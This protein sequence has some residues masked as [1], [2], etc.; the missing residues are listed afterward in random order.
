MKK[1][2]ALTIVL[3]LLLSGFE[4]LGYGSGLQI[5]P[6][7]IIRD[8]IISYFPAVKG[9]IEETEGGYVRLH[10]DSS[11]D[12]NTGTRLS[13]FRESGMIYHPVTKEPLG[14]AETPVGR[15]EVIRKEGRSYLCSIIKG[16]IRK[17]DIARI[18]SSKIKLAFFQKRGSDWQLSQSLYNA[19]K[20]SNRFEILETF[21]KTF[22]PERLS[23]IS[24]ELGAEVL[25]L[26]ST[27]IEDGKRFFNVELYWTDD[28]VRF[29]RIHEPAG[30]ESMK[31]LVP[32]GGFLSFSPVDTEPWGSYDLGT[33]ELIA[34]GDV[35]GDG[36]KEIVVSDGRNIKIY[37]FKD[38][39]REVWRIG[40]RSGERHLS[41]DILDLN[42]NGRGEIFVTSITGMESGLTRD[43]SSFSPAG[44][45][46]I[47]SFI[48]EYSHD[49]GYK[50]IREDMPY[51]FRVVNDR[52]LMQG[53]SRNNIFNGPV[54]EVLWE[55]GEYRPAKPIELPE[56]VNIYGFAYIQWRNNGDTYLLSFDPEGYL[57][58]YK[59]GEEIWRSGESFGRFYLTFERTTHSVSKPVEKWSIK[60]RLP[61]IKTE[62]GQEAIV[63]KKN[64]VLSN[65]PG[66]GYSD[67]S[68]YLLWWNGDGLE[69]SLVMRNLPGIATD[70]LLSDDE[71]FIIAKGSLFSFV[72]NAFAGKFSRGSKLYYYRFIEQ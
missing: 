58:L 6:A 45:G 8:T 49:E 72:K 65:V 48:I 35:D 61:I 55:G 40:G 44:T 16:D 12:L 46:S 13:V 4:G 62:R 32:E 28:A 2:I 39:P 38:G 71:L 10:I 34:M 68:V 52:L 9:L 50:R 57:I 19:L 21:T 36:S 47:K 66:L 25:L 22:K 20:E 33:G 51:F 56:G 70:Y 37:I 27:P 7:H 29:A 3:L 53:F 15:I 41:I 43:E 1:T 30:D 67:F 26:M 31:L 69:E 5:D 23:R 24:K 54:Y 59:G 18:T 42:G 17:G 60:G 11:I 64:P 63:I 14:R